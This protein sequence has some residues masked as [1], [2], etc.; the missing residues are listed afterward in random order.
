MKVIGVIACFMVTLAIAAPAPAS[1]DSAGLDARENVEGAKLERRGC[2]AGYSCQNGK[3]YHKKPCPD[4]SRDFVESRI[5]A[6][7]VS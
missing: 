5:M 1:G 7:R 4:S 2:P 3:C 6:G